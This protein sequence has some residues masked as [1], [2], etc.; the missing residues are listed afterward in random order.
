MPCPPFPLNHARSGIV[1]G[2]AHAGGEPDP[3]VRVLVDNDP[4]PRVVLNQRI[5]DEGHRRPALEV[6][7]VATGILDD[8]TVHRDLVSRVDRQAVKAA[9]DPEPANGEVRDAVQL[10]RVVRGVRTGDGGRA[11]AVE[12]D[13]VELAGGAADGDIFVASAIDVDRVARPHGPE[14]SLKRL[15]PVAVDD[16]LPVV[17]VV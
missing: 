10:Q 15:S 8:D 12:G 4:V 11:F 5:D 13:T 16:P 2:R 1:F 7:P 9:R 6:Y 14:H 3:R 17:I